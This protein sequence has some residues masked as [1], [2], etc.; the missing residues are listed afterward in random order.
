MI[1]AVAVKMVDGVIEFRPDSGDEGLANYL[2]TLVQ[3]AKRLGESASP[4]VLAKSGL[5]GIAFI[6]AGQEEKIR[7]LEAQ[8]EV[9]SERSMDT[10]LAKELRD[11]NGARASKARAEARAIRD[12]L[13][14]S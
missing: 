3:E 1:M 4:G 8:A 2:C 12:E 9:W 10:G 14:G 11:L 7:A 13:D 6:R 5:T